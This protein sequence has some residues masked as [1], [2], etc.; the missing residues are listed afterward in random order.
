MEF[1]A[2]IIILWTMLTSRSI[3]DPGYKIIETLQPSALSEN[4][5]NVNFIEATWKIVVPL[6]NT[7]F[8]NELSYVQT[9][10]SNLH[11]FCNV[12]ATELY[13]LCS[14]INN[15][16][17]PIVEHI[18]HNNNVISHYYNRRVKR[19]WFNGFGRAANTLFGVM[20]DTDAE[21]LNA[22]IEELQNTQ[23]SEKLITDQHTILLK[24]QMNTLEDVAKNTA[25]QLHVI[26]MNF[27]MLNTTIK[28][29]EFVE[30][31]SNFNSI[32]E[33]FL[34]ITDT[35][36][37]NQQRIVEIL[38]FAKSNK[39]HPTLLSDAEFKNIESKIMLKPGFY[40]A[41]N[42]DII[43]SIQIKQVNPHKI[44]FEI[45][46]PIFNNLDIFRMVRIV[47]LPFKTQNSTYK[48]IIVKYTYIIINNF[49]EK[50][51]GLTTEQ[52]STFCSLSE[53]T[54]TCKKG[55][56][57]MYSHTLKPCELE[58]ALKYKHNS[59][60]DSII[61]IRNNLFSL[62]ENH[63]TIH[64]VLST[65]ESVNIICNDKS[66][67]VN[68]NNSGIIQFTEDCEIRTNSFTQHIS[69]KTEGIVEAEFHLFVNKAHENINELQQ[70]P[71]LH[72]LK[73]LPEITHIEDIGQMKTQINSLEHI[74][75]HN[76]HL[77]TQKISVH[78]ITIYVILSLLVMVLSIYLMYKHIKKTYY[79]FTLKEN[80]TQK[81][82]TDL[83]NSTC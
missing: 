80:T 78:D 23:K 48:T 71:H 13:K 25:K 38:I 28:T 60:L 77:S 24:T 42:F 7:Y 66:N 27:K 11:T 76:L 55:L 31:K 37:R 1:T 22:N 70:L 10:R 4:L 33:E 17:S 45:S 43:S 8:I 57:M 62:L 19:G 56:Q 49:N 58:L 14:R 9:L 16:I 5:G 51:M 67:Y 30:I 26:K 39:I 50:S 61:Y 63:N 44:I 29:L 69:S 79:S 52:R 41:K 81:T 72:R 20:D 53:R 59:C 12:S 64:Y 21:K 3:A 15:E 6:D 40:L 18:E 75:I 2:L 54:Y 68:L 34:L 32:V 47:P 83:H 65:I 74:D 35:I 36:I 73:E 46:V 82:N